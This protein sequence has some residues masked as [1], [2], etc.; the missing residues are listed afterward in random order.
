[1]KPTKNQLFKRQIT[2]SE[3]GEV[4]QKKLQNASVLVVGCGGAEVPL[5]R[6]GAWPKRVRTGQRCRGKPLQSLN[7]N[8]RS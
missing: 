2:L 4:G 6:R 1:M 7:D 3:I 5:Q 8:S